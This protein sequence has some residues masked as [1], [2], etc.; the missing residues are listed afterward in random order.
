MGTRTLALIFTALTVACGGSPMR[1]S[2]VAP[3]QA[4]PA[5]VPAPTPA[6]FGAVPFSPA[7]GAQLSGPGQPGLSFSV[8]LVAKDAGTAEGVVVDTFQFARDRDFTVNVQTMSAPR[9][10]GQTS[11]TLEVQANTDFY[12]RVR[13][14]AGE[15]ISAF[16]ETFHFKTA[17]APFG[18]PTPRRPARSS[19]QSGPLELWVSNVPHD[20]RRGAWT[21]RFEI[22]TDPDFTSVVLAKDVQEFVTEDARVVPDRALPR[23]QPLFWHA[24]TFDGAAARSNF[25]ETWSFTIGDVVLL[26]PTLVAPL[27]GST[28]MQRP[29]LTMVLAEFAFNPNAAEG[30]VQLATNPAFAPSYPESGIIFNGSAIT[31]DVLPPGKYYWRA[32]MA[33]ASADFRTTTT[34]AWTEAWT[35]TVTPPVIQ[36]PTAISPVFGSTV[37]AHPMLT[38]RNA[39]RSGITGTLLYRFE[40]ATTFDFRSNT[41]VASQTVPESPGQTSWTVTPDLPAGVQ[42]YWR[43]QV[44]DPASGAVSPL[45]F[46]A[47]AFAIVRTAT[48]LYALIITLPSPCPNAQSFFFSGL[49]DDAIGDAH[50]VFHLATPDGA[51]AATSTLEASVDRGSGISGTIGGSFGGITVKG[52][53]G[54]PAALTGQVNPDGAMS[55]TFAGTVT[56]FVNPRFPSNCSSTAFRWSI[57][58]RAGG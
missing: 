43:V 7:N 39:V 53:G 57:A 17:A 9:G 10:P 19:V 35:F 4:V 52:D 32:R 54:A 31:L 34:S 5:P 13:A 18:P 27:S 8:T 12:W 23:S 56:S 58:P 6:A 16:S 15:S 24:Q 48:R 1:P 25:S 33:Q 44:S 11:V 14:A 38:V 42:M 30:Q 46:P 50:F 51:P 36:T 47:G 40:V 22:A 29:T 26:P 41:V 49:S 55:G 21:D 2:G 3:T 28:V 37:H 20:D 45:Q